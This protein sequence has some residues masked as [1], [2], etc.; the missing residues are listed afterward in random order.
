MYILY[1]FYFNFLYTKTIKKPK[2]KQR[3]IFQLLEKFLFVIPIHMTVLKILS[4]KQSRSL[5]CSGKDFS[6]FLL[7]AIVNS[8]KWCSPQK[9]CPSVSSAVGA[10]F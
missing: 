2:K 5:I 9:V 3:S 1:T 10:V 6:T 7:S 4:S 8:C